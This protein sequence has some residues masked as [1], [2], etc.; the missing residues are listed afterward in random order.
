M[1]SRSFPI[2]CLY[3]NINTFIE[4]IFIKNDERFANFEQPRDKH[5]FRAATTLHFWRERSTKSATAIFKGIHKQGWVIVY[6][7]ILN[8][9]NINFY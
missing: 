6:M 1:D 8:L 4:L 9:V 3:T 7:S 2:G 5:L